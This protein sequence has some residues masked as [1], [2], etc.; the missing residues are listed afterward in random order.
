MEIKIRNKIINFYKLTIFQIN[1]YLKNKIWELLFIYSNF[2]S[3]IFF[4]SL[5]LYSKKEA[6]EF[7]LIFNLVSILTLSLSANARNISILRAGSIY[8]EKVIKFRLYSSLVIFFIVYFLQSFLFIR[9]TIFFLSINLLALSFWVIEPI[10]TLYE[11]KKKNFKLSILLIFSHFF[12]CLNFL[13]IYYIYRQKEVLI[14]FFFTLSFVNIFYLVDFLFL[15]KSLIIKYSYRKREFRSQIL[16]N[17]AFLSS[18]FIISS[19]FLIRYFL[20][21]K[22]DYDLAADVI[23]CLSIVSFP[24][25][26]ITGFYGAKYLNKDIILPSIFKYIFIFYLLSF[27]LSIAILS[28]NLYPLYDN[29]LKLFCLSLI[30]SLFIFI[31]QVFRT[32]HIGSMNIQSVFLKDIFFHVVLFFFVYL[33]ISYFN[34]YLLFLIYPLMAFVTYCSNMKLYDFDKKK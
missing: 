32:L 31:A 33:S 29:F 2:F 16:N 23:F 27:F 10:I 12:I 7:L 8:L 4:N 34:V 25:T 26:L 21:K 24:G 15:K 14:L 3:I 17:L 20:S 30:G 13:F 6:I 18:I 19:V 11:I 22:L 1:Y 9:E 28:M 5:Y